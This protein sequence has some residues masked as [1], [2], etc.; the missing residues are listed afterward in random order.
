MNFGA[1]AG[2]LFVHWLIYQSLYV[3]GALCPYCM[4]VWVVTIPVFWYTT[5]HT[6]RQGMVPERLRRILTDYHG[7]V[8]TL[9]YVILGVAVLRAFWSYWLTVI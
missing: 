5:L 4:I 7:V 3:I 6:M 1:L 9:W 8:L 2:V